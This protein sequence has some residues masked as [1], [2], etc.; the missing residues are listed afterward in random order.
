MSPD[1]SDH[2]KGGDSPATQA[3][4][5][6]PST[7]DHTGGEHD[8]HPTADP[9]RRD[10]RAYHL[11]RVCARFPTTI[12]TQGAHRLARLFRVSTNESS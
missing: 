4:T 1:R 9:A 7:T 2:Q 11:A 5:T 3:I 6:V 10:D 8:P 12:S